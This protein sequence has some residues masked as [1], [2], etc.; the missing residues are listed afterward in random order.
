MPLFHFRLRN[1]QLGNNHL[2]Y[3]LR[4]WLQNQVKKFHRRLNR[5]L[6]LLCMVDTLHH[7]RRL[8]V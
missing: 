1:L 2:N 4:Q 5:L 3:Q 6:M 7:H 8:I